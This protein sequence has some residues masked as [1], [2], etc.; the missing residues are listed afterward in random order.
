[1]AAGDD[2]SLRRFQAR[3]NAIPKAV[4]EAV[5]PALAKGAEEIAAA[6][7]TLAPEDSGDLRKSI[8]VTGPGQRT[9][10]YSHPGGSRMVAENEAAV[11]AGNSE[12]R[13]AHLV[14]Y[15]TEKAPA[16]SFFWPA[17]RS[18]RKRAASRVKRAMSKAVKEAGR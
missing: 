7:R 9:P 13:Y 3:M 1:M 4:R 10:P 14:E 5:K 11:T 6:A 17:F 2:A 16:Q 12:V 18:M 15:G 8:A